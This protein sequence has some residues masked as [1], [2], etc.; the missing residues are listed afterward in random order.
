MYFS[1]TYVHTGL[2]SPRGF[3][4]IQD[5]N[6][7][8]SFFWEDPVLPNII[9]LTGFVLFYNVTDAFN[10]TLSEFIAISPN[11]NFYDFN[12]ACSYESGL[13]L[14]PSSQYCFE[15]RGAYRRNK[16][17]SLTIPSDKIC[18]TTPEYCKKHY[19]I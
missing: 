14:C 4:H 18:L 16:V 3:R 19:T 10:R 12:K 8:V 17:S 5:G 6:Y 13:A 2:N 7:N 11:D 9:Q 15:L 1:I